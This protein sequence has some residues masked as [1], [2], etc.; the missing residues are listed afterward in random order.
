MFCCVWNK[1]NYI[2]KAST[3]HSS[4]A[5]II[6]LTCDYADCYEEFDTQE[7]L[8]NHSRAHMDHRRYVCRECNK[9]FMTRENLHNHVCTIKEISTHGS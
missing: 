1:D 6:K 9:I 3:N 8:D 4:D 5:P 7:M 2:T